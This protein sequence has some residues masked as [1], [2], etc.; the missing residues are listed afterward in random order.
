MSDA[1][2]MFGVPIGPPPGAPG[3]PEAPILPHIA[4]TPVPP[5]MP[6]FGPSKAPEAPPM[7]GVSR[8]AMGIWIAV[9]AVILIV[10]VFV[11]TQVFRGF[12]ESGLPGVQGGVSCLLDSGLDEVGSAA[13]LDD[14]E[15]FVP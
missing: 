1:N 11:A 12:S 13:C 14:V 8:L 6:D 9:A 15:P 5:A 3:S 4:A 10:G 2:G 7:S